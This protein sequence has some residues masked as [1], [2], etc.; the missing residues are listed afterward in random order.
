CLQISTKAADVELIQRRDTVPQAGAD[1]SLRCELQ[2]LECDGEVR[3]LRGS[4]E[5]LRIRRRTIDIDRGVDLRARVDST[6][7]NDV[8]NV[9]HVDAGECQLGMRLILALQRGLSGRRD[10]R[11]DERGLDLIVDER[12]GA[13]RVQRHSA[14][15]V[16]LVADIRKLY[17]CAKI[18]LLNRA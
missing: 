3:E 4:R 16:A 18:R 1:R 9:G 6:R 14:N 13:V 5:L 7:R 12:A 8:E 2:V 10:L 11:A 15:L 17:L